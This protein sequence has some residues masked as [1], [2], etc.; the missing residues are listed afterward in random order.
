[1]FVACVVPS[2]LLVVLV[3]KDLSVGEALVRLNCAH[4]AQ[5]FTHVLMTTTR[6]ARLEP[7]PL[8]ELDGGTGSQ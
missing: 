1:M 4:F 5:H 6:S 3:M 8:P 7:L 2:T